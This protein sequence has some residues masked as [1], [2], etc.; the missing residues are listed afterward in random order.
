L[1]ITV[2]TL[3]GGS[4]NP[5][6]GGV[7]Y[8]KPDTASEVLANLVVAGSGSN[9]VTANVAT[10]LV[11][12]A[13]LSGSGELIKKGSGKLTLG[14]DSNAF[15]G[16]ITIQ[17][18]EIEIMSN[19][20]LGQ[21]SQVLLEGAA[22]KVT[23][24]NGAAISTNVILGNQAV[25]AF[26]GSGVISGPIAGAGKF[27]KEG[28]GRIELTG[29]NTY[30]G[31]TVIRS[32]VLQ[33]GNGGAGGSISTSSRIINDS[34]FVINQSDIVRQ[35][36]DFTS[37]AITGIGSFTASGS[38]TTVLIAN[39][40]YEGETYIN[41]GAD[42]R[43]NGNHAG[44]GDVNVAADSHLGGSGSVKGDV[45]VDGTLSPGNSIESFGTS[46]VNFSI[47]SMYAYEIN[48][49]ILAADLLYSD[50]NV[51][52]E[53]GT[54]LGLS[55]LSSTSTPI[56]GTKFTL[57]SSFGPW[58]GG[59]FQ[60]DSGAGLVPLLDD[61]LFTFGANTWLMNYNDT[62]PGVNFIDDT[63][64]ASNFITMTAVPE[65]GIALFLGSFGV[66]SLMCRRRA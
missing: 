54:I 21:A 53:W 52:I 49:A 56:T 18:G 19:T 2:D 26:D 9:R 64:G 31:Q 51:N 20:A 37:E 40:A 4:L 60:Y 6:A 14:G 5:G 66:F 29:N 65:S 30:V 38:G 45:Y 59:L 43:I 28:N 55:D 3:L 1:R 58:N 36:I 50:G 35:G 33:L 61:S 23:L 46:T 8:D 32:G 57:I 12:S 16:Q 63:S 47:G 7:I 17:S 10:N 24:S 62:S 44:M 11:L 39:N 41:S 25:A 48:S 27:I 42:L 22:S 34:A 15:S 13:G